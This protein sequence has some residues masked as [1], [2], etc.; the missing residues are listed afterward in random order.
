M[1]LT[2]FVVA[3]DEKVNT[4]ED[5]VLCVTSRARKFSVFVWSNGACVEANGGVWYDGFVDSCLARLRA[6]VILEF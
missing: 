5:F 1:G 2:C 4:L 6:L 3:I